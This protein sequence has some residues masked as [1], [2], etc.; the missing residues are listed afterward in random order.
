MTGVILD[1][2]PERAA[3]FGKENI[4]FH[5]DLHTRALFSDAGLADLLDRY[6]R[7]RLGVFTMGEDPVAW[8]TWRRGAAGD[9]TGAELLAGVEAGRIWLNLR[10]ANQHLS[11]YAAL[12]RDIFADIEASKPDFT[13][14]R[15]DVGVLI[16]SPSVQVFYHLDTAPVMLWQIRGRKRMWVYPICEPFVSDRQLEAV[17]LRETAEQMPFDA[18]WDASAEVFDLEPGRMVSWR[19]NA[20]HRVENADMLN[21]SLSIEYLTPG[22]ALR[23][24]EIYANGFLR[25][26]FGLEPRLSGGPRAAVKAIVARGVKALGLARGIETTLPITFRLDR[27]RPGEVFGV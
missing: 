10:A 9:L 24:N 18:A 21:V 2:S 8:R 27:S 23:A 3:A 4:L 13:A 20:P 16:S 12:E 19:Q 26:R 17:V 14:F 11:E 15:R 22:A 1:W 25:R 6:P 7:D 5:H